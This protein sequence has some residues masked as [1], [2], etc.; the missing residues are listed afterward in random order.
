MVLQNQMKIN[1]L[2]KFVINYVGFIAAK[3]TVNFGV[4]FTIES[5]KT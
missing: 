2:L 1:P 4:K 5:V 3:E